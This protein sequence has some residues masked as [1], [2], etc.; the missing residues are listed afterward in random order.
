MSASSLGL[1]AAWEKIDTIRKRFRSDISWIQ[2]PIP[3]KPEPTDGEGGSEVDHHPICTKALELNCEAI[4]AMV[5]AFDGAFCDIGRVEL[6][7]RRH[8]A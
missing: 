1:A 3:E 7:A 6:E 2:W 8:R 4:Q 5:V